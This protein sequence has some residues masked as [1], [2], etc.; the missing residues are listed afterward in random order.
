M[1]EVKITNEIK[2]TQEPMETKDIITFKKGDTVYDRKGKSIVKKASKPKQGTPQFGIEN[3]I[4]DIKRENGSSAINMPASGFS[5]TPIQEAETPASKEVPPPAFTHKFKVGDEGMWHGGERKIK[6]FDGIG[7]V[8]ITDL[9]NPEK[10]T[11]V[12]IESFDKE[13]TLFPKDDYPAPM[14]EKPAAE[15]R[16]ELKEIFDKQLAAY[17]ETKNKH[18]LNQISTELGVYWDNIV[19]PNPEELAGFLDLQKNLPNKIRVMAEWAAV[20]E[21][22]E[23]FLENLKTNLWKLIPEEFKQHRLPKKVLYNP[24]HTDKGLYSITSEF[25][26]YDDLRPIMMGVHFDKEGITATDANKLLFLANASDREEAT[27]C[28]TKD[29]L[30]A[31]E[32]TGS[33]IQQKYPKYKQVV[34]D[35]TKFVTIYAESLINYLKTVIAIKY[36][37][38]VINEVIIT[39]D[40]DS[41]FA[42]NARLLLSSA[43]AMYK[44]GYEQIDI[45]YSLSHRAVTLCKKGELKSVPKFT[46]DFALVMPIMLGDR[47]EFF[48][49]RMYF[50]AES[51]CV[52]TKGIAD[53]SCINPVEIEKQKTAQVLD[54]AN[55]VLAQ[56]KEEIVKHDSKLSAQKIADKLMSIEGKV[57]DFLQIE[58]GSSLYDDILLQRRYKKE[59]D[60][61][62]K[63]KFT[64]PLPKSVYDILEAENYHPLNQY[65]EMSGAFGEDEKEKYFSYF[66]SLSD[67]RKANMLNASLY[68]PEISVE[69]KPAEPS[70]PSKEILTTRLK[71]VKKMYAKNKSS[72]LKTRIK[73]IEKMLLATEKMSVGGVVG[74]IA[75]GVTGALAAQKLLNDKSESTKE[76]F[77]YR[78]AYLVGTSPTEKF[79]FFSKRA[80]AKV[81]AKKLMKSNSHISVDKLKEGTKN[82]WETVT[83]YAGLA[84]IKNKKKPHPV[85]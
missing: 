37:H 12:S 65:L 31:E 3:Q 70:K 15:Q 6:G 14:K 62:T 20:K 48:N 17:D 19:A 40:A 81:L 76:P 61:R 8:I 36:F 79:E 32:K 43:E 11:K 50:N 74:A 58:S 46:T 63:G 51:E 80:E 44:L 26:G 56:A 68:R 5:L 21:Y 29:C 13:F 30:K 66:D 64:Y 59:L 7:N 35:N 85:A 72:T 42:F 57:W 34:P 16:A 77:R 18:L 22:N 82:D 45:G 84:N 54:K 9:D 33:I 53:K 38:N 67:E 10:E 75:M 25:V 27:Y 41:E 24:E 2:P 73:I 71:I 83:A 47:V 49:G 28:L 69:S 4:L 55:E 78:V 60:E 39:F 23:R 1:Q 52:A